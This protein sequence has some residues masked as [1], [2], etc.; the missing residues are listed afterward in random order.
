VSSRRD[1]QAAAD[2]AR[3]AAYLMSGSL[4]YARGIADDVEAAIAGE[5]G[6]EAL[7]APGAGGEAEPGASP[8]GVVARCARDLDGRPARTLPL[9]A[10]AAGRSGPW[11]EP[12]PD[13]L[14]PELPASPHLAPRETI[15][16][17]FVAALQYLPP[18]D[19]AAIV[20]G[21]VLAPAWPP[22]TAAPAP[23]GP[24]TATDAALA[25][26]HARLVRAR[27]ALVGTGGGAGTPDGESTA[28]DEAAL[29]LRLVFHCESADHDGLAALLA[30][31]ATLQCVP[32]GVTLRGREAVADGL[33]R[34]EATAGR[35]SPGPPGLPLAPGLRRLLPRRA[36]GRLAFGAYRRRAHGEPFRAHCLLVVAMSG[37]LATGVVSFALPSL[38]SAFDL[39]G[40]L[41][42]QGERQRA[43]QM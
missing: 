9:W 19:R 5:S 32:D 16:L 38:F 30:A 11:L 25:A 7:A 20:L 18:E 15:D 24:G 27:A 4:R 8:A 10:G 33:L 1:P 22:D 34:G 37:P 6:A 2:V 21:D 36:N 40:E 31:D 12:F 13:H 14:Y 43:E 28:G 42:P 41:A 23:H 17:A 3:L 26:A 39:L 29:M 35:R